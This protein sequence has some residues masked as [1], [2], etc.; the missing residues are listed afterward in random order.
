MPDVVQRY[1]LR[2]R[3]VRR[4]RGGQRSRYSVVREYDIGDEQYTTGTRRHDR[5]SDVPRRSCVLLYSEG[6][7]VT[8]PGVTPGARAE[9]TPGQLPR[10][11]SRLRFVPLS[12]ARPDVMQYCV[13]LWGGRRHHSPRPSSFSA[14]MCAPVFGLDILLSICTHWLRK[15]M[16]NSQALMSGCVV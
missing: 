7:R 14:F 12:G 10:A 16:R 8:N 13:R 1:R 2:S 4:V 9:L 3:R 5:M 15:R 6:H 11:L